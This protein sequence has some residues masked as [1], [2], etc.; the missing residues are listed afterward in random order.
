[1]VRK[2]LSERQ[3]IFWIGLVQ[4]VNILDFMMVMPLG[5]DFAKDLG[6]PANDLGWIG[7]TYTMMAAIS[8][9]MG[10]MIMDKF[11][12]KKALLCALAGLMCSTWLGALAIDFETLMCTR[13][14]AGLFGGPV[15]SLSLAIL[16]DLIP[17]ERRGQ[18]MGKVMSAFSLA[19][20]LGVPIGLEL[21]RLSSWTTPF[22]TT[23]GLALL[24]WIALW[25]ILPTMKNHMKGPQ[26]HM[27]LIMFF[28]ESKYLYSFI[29]MFCGMMAAFIMIPNIS[30]YVQYNLGFPRAHLGLLYMAGGS[31]SFFIMRLVGKLADR[32]A[33]SR[34]TTVSTMIFIIVVYFSFVDYPQWMPV[35]FL[36]VGFMGA[37]SVRGV[38]VGTLTS[39]VPAPH[40]RAR[41]T[42]LLS[43]FQHAASATGAFLGAAIL[44]QENGKLVGIEK[45][46]FIS[47]A[48]S[49]IVP[50]AMLRIEQHL[51]REH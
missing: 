43:A 11:D 32:M 41:F 16:S 25:R 38:A 35:F 33:A 22:W 7:G 27:P 24:V 15:T 12:R 5:P 37:L 29:A 21:A 44:T 36:F 1:M 39:K 30:A 28:Q 6:I 45:I 19:S 2:D 3:V 10:A 48:V 17:P 9:V 46:A 13:V 14:L 23:G 49:L 8:G 20:V 4:F 51:Q 26:H 42:S 50:M 18:A 47:I 31:A 40:I 34:I